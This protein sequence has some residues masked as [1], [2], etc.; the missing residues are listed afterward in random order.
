MNDLFFIMYFGSIYSYFFLVIF[1]DFYILSLLRSS[2]YMYLSYDRDSVS[3]PG[4]PQGEHQ[5][6]IC[7]ASSKLAF[8]VPSSP[9]DSCKSP[10][11][12]LSGFS[13]TPH[14]SVN[15]EVHDGLVLPVAPSHWSE[16]L[17]NAAPTE[18]TGWAPE[19]ES[20]ILSMKMQSTAS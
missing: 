16:R 3:V 18:T 20:E 2:L 10:F 14:H 1:I 6:K 19:G 5:W 11:L 7:L 17:T 12:F 8:F 9:W 4:S 13:D 15:Q